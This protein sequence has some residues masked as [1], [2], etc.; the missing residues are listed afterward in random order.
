MAKGQAGYVNSLI[1][2]TT[3]GA[4]TGDGINGWAGG[5]VFAFRV[6]ERHVEVDRPEQTTTDGP[7]DEAVGGPV[8]ANVRLRGYFKGT[9]PDSTMQDEFILVEATTAFSF[10]GV[11]LVTKFRN[12]GVVDQAVQFEIEGRTDGTFINA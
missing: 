6:A 11:V 10:I 1:Q 12:V 5:N 7:Y 2:I 4:Y 3:G 9:I 8:K